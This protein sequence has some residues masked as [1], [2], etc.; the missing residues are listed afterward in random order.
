MKPEGAEGGQ[1][2]QGSSVA[3]AAGSGLER[4]TREG[5]RGTPCPQESEA[6]SRESEA[7][8]FLHFLVHSLA[9]DLIHLDQRGCWGWRGFPPPVPQVAPLVMQALPSP[10]LEDGG[11][12][13]G[14]WQGVSLL[15]SRTC[16]G[17]L[18]GSR[19]RGVHV[20]IRGV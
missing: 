1:A 12:W 11:L 6:L 9:L 18:A 2:S 10:G 17:S 14:P 8:S 19:N 3:W 20:L 16:G 4:S 7:L 15:N 5:R 13:V